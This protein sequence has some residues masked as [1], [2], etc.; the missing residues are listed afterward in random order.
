MSR[1]PRS[2]S[3]CAESARL[4]ASR[5]EQSNKCKLGLTTRRQSIQATGVLMAFELLPQPNVGRIRATSAKAVLATCNCVITA[6][7][8]AISPRWDRLAVISTAIVV[9]VVVVLHLL[10][11]RKLFLLQA[12]FIPNWRFAIGVTWRH[13]I[14]LNLRHLGAAKLAK[15]LQWAARL[16]RLQ[17]TIALEQ[18]HEAQFSAIS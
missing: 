18:A 7:V 2:E 8:A 4:P 17:R 14:A 12:G 5:L 15:R 9:V 6:A 3:R 11:S 13:G 16:L 1:D 10:K